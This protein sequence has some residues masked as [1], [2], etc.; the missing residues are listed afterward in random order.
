MNNHTQPK[1]QS[2]W[3]FEIVVATGALLCL[4][5]YFNPRQPKDLVCIEG[6]DK[7]PNV[8]EH[9]DV[10]PG[11][12]LLLGLGYRYFQLKEYPCLFYTEIAVP[13]YGHDT[14][15]KVH[16]R[17]KDYQRLQD[18]K[19]G[20]SDKEIEIRVYA[21]ETFDPYSMKWTRYV[22]EHSHGHGSLFAFGI[23]LSILFLV[24][25][26]KKVFFNTATKKFP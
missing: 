9:R 4:L 6:Y 21:E 23:L 8:T 1:K 13:Y 20:V 15:V 22:A 7:Y 14:P 12:M 26:V 10:F 3:L 16:I 11:S 18:I 17:A 5:L 19:N 2:S 24:M 25:V